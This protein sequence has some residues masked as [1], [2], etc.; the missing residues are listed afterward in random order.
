MKRIFYPQ[1]IVVIGVS[2]RPDNLARN[3]IANLRAFGYQG[4][5]FAVGRQSGE[6]HGVPIVTG[7]EQV[8][9]HVD[10]AVILTPAAVVPDLLEACGRK[11]ILR[12]VIES[13]GFSEFSEEG[14]GL[15]A[16]LLA[17]ARRWGI[18][19]VGPNCISVVNM[20]AGVCLP[21]PPISPDPVRRGTVSVLA[22][23][24]GVSITYL[25]LLSAA[26]V[27]VNKVVSMGNKTDLAETDYLSYL[28]DDP[29]TEIVCLYLESVGD[30][31]QLMDLARSGTKPLIVHKANRGQASQ[32]IAFSHTAALADDDRIVSAALRQAGA[33]RAEDFR[34]AVSI[35][36]GLSLPPVQGDDL[37]VISRSGG[38]AV[39]AADAAE[40][41]G[42]RLPPIPESFA[43]AVRDLFRADVIALTNP[44]DLG[45][46]FDFDLYAR[47]VEECLR[48]L[49]PDA[50]LLVNTYSL[51]E[52]EGGRRLAR[53]VESIVQETG[54]PVAFCVYAQG[55][56]KHTVQREV[57]LPIFADIEDALQGLSAA[58]ERHRWQERHAG[59]AVR[60]VNA[61]PEENPLPAE[62]GAL[63]T[64]RALRLCQKYGIAV[65]P[66][67]VA[68]DPDEAVQAADRLGYPV[69]L[70]V[71]SAEVVHKS[72]VGGVALGLTDAEA[73][74]QQAQAMLARVGE[75]VPEAEP[76]AL[77]VQRMVD[78]GVEVIL[79]GKRDASFGP[80]VMFGLGGVH[81]EVF[82][83]VAFRV[84]PLGR[85]DAEDMIREVRGSRL[86]EGVRGRAPAD[87]ETLIEALLGLS[88]LMME[89]PRVVEVDVNPLLV[90]EEGAV[91]VDARAVLE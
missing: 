83:D 45:T 56:E 22:Q 53:K 74:R 11:G 37:V 58:R 9:D 17:V 13:G 49:A 33:F 14:R 51:A 68:A 81:V 27:G 62:S 73:V 3:I 16:E 57:D 75:T 79:G 59:T 18:R 15:E 76:A 25:D 52:V 30:G 70:K 47:I 35:A 40:R 23:S 87:R 50:I 77:M 10:L 19:F 67:E 20:E 34:G 64:D 41:H 32:R 39:I 28:M 2:E 8:P 6:V 86:L 61:P 71:L 65:A 38:H 88:Q 1:S 21:F 85:A 78:A 43:A 26:G 42:F 72:D 5:L 63:S 54:R 91:A 84:A 82:D 66:W 69:A 7:L 36:Q 48:M 90:L 31:R 60:S 4:D 80:V 55:T 89:N 46:I 24:G 29:G 12:V 44:L